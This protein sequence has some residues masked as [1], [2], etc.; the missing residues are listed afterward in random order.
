[1]FS[2]PKYAISSLSLGSNTYHDLPTKIRVASGLGYDG[3]EIFSEYL[4]ALESP[5]I[6][7]ESCCSVA[8]FE[9]FVDQV[10]RGRHTSL[11]AP[12]ASSTSDSPAIECEC[13]TAVSNLCTS[14]SINCS[15]SGTF[16]ISNPTKP[17]FKPS[18]APNDGSKLLGAS[19][20]IW[21]SSVQILSRDLVLSRKPGWR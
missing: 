12:Q 20:Q 18:M 6:G 15:L 13:A 9:S 10:K 14:L 1:M 7:A 3:I 2:E 16:R 11:F 8:D 17:S 5:H 21:S 19:V 4:L